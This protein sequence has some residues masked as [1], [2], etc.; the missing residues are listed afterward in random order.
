MNRSVKIPLKFLLFVR[1]EKKKR[2]NCLYCI[3][4]LWLLNLSSVCCCCCDLQQTFLA[5]TKLLLLTE[6]FLYV[7]KLCYTDMK[8]TFIC[9]SSYSGE[10]APSH[11][12]A[13]DAQTTKRWCWKKPRTQRRDHHR[14]DD[15]TV[16]VTSW[17]PYTFRFWT[18]PIYSYF[19]K[20]Y[21][22]AF[23]WTNEEP[24]ADLT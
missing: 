2:S 21:L 7:K 10:E 14:G 23:S 9:L 12:E 24:G 4:S 6:G 15:I 20:C 16:I 19:F 22:I 8:V 5:N 13:H 11:F 17:Q 3:Y 18:F 1:K